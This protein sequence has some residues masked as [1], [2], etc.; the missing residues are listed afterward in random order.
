LNAWQEQ[1]QQ[2]SLQNAVAEYERLLAFQ[3]LDDLHALARRWNVKLSN[4]SKASVVK[5]LAAQFSES[6]IHQALHQEQV[7]DVGYRI[8]TY[9][10][11]LVAPDYGL[12]ADR[13]VRGMLHHQQRSAQPARPGEPVLSLYDE[14]WGQDPGLRRKLY[15]QIAELAES[16]L[17][18]SFKQKNVLYYTLPNLVRSHLPPQP[19]LVPAYAGDLDALDIRETTFG[20][21]VHDLF[22]AWN[23]LSRDLAGKGSP[24]LWR[25]A[26]SRQPI[27]DQW[28][29]LRGWTHEPAEL[30]ILTRAESSGA[31]PAP[32]RLDRV[33]AATL[34]WAMTVPAPRPRLRDSERQQIRDQIKGTDAQ[35]EFYCAVLEGLG[36]LSGLPGEPIV[37]HKGALQRFLR[38]S[39][40]AKMRAIWDAWASEQAWSEM[41]VVLE[42]GE[43][44]LLRLRRSLAHP[45]YKEKDLYQEWYTA[46][47][48]VLRFVSLFP[49]G[50]WLSIDGLLKTVFDM[51]PNLLHATSDRSV[52][53]LESSRTGRQYGT[54]F[55]DWQQSYGQ[56]V[57]SVLCG[58]LYWLGIVRLGYAQ[59]PNTDTTRPPG[60]PV[61]VQLTETGL[62]VLGRRSVLDSEQAS[63]SMPDESSC[64]ISENLTVS[65]V[66]DRAP[67]HVHNL[68]HST[69]RLLDATPDRFV[70]QMTAEGVSNWLRA[71]TDE[72]AGAVRAKGSIDTLISVLT[73]HCHSANTNWRE[74]LRTWER[75]RGLLHI[76]E[77]IALLELADDYALQELLISTSLADHLVYQ[78]SPRLIAIWADGIDGLADEMEKRGYTPRIR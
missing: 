3:K 61:A 25:S 27:E 23:T 24:L 52:W 2:A 20:I 13:I 43:Q 37:V 73:K 22:A 67:L 53:W 46:R 32:L 51:H 39:A 58:P 68:L 76:Y 54:A 45:D 41:R 36:A 6:R 38:L 12:S 70:Y 78:F 59:A 55:E 28:S 77:N 26:P 48:V 14:Q 33:S 17:L 16:G 11:L 30:S 5:Q 31:R 18:L 10:H 44:R 1:N 71:Q 66:P 4:G 72:K 21:V 74:T 15:E 19:S 63:R 29:L 40:S 60:Q 7:E 75:N 65:L 47:Q 49:D 69:G 64:S 34:N 50:Q 35:T 62:F 9:M 8:L 56:F 57:L 42:P